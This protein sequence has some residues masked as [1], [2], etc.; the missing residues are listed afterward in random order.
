MVSKRSEDDKVAKKMKIKK[1]KKK[2]K[3]AGVEA[4]CRRE[5]EFLPGKSG[6]SPLMEARCTPPPPPPPAAPRAV[7]VSTPVPSRGVRVTP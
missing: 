2:K 4:S 7:A 1:K 6:C 3:A 5:N